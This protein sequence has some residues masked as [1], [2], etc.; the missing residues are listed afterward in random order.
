MVVA[1][2]LDSQDY[3]PAVKDSFAIPTKGW[4]HAHGKELKF[5]K[6]KLRDK[7]VQAYHDGLLEESTVT[8]QFVK[9]A[10]EKQADKQK[11]TETRKREHKHS[12]DQTKRRKLDWDDFRGKSFYQDASIVHAKKKGFTLTNTMIKTASCSFNSACMRDLDPEQPMIAYPTL[13]HMY[14][15]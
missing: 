13:P 4:T 14:M 12:D 6:D 1:R 2:I 7:K 15:Q 11:T 3:R 5:Q 8:D 10:K 9:L